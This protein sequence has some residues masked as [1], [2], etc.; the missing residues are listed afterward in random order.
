MLDHEMDLLEKEFLEKHPNR[1]FV[2]ANT[3]ATIDFVKNLKVMV[4]GN[5]SKHQ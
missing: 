3:V 1:F 4:D 2:Y 5:Y